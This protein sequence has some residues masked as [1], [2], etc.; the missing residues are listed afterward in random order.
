MDVA[1]ALLAISYILFDVLDLDGSN[2]C[3]FVARTSRLNNTVA[4][5]TS[6]IQIDDSQE[7]TDL[8]LDRRLLPAHL[9]N[10][11]AELHR[12]NTLPIRLTATA[13]SHGDRGC[14]PEHPVTDPS[15]D[16]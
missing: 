5:V 2:T 3:R 6:E 9:S 7:P 16:H 14:R 10:A 12:L 15:P 11:F 1:C 4:E 8:R 13:R